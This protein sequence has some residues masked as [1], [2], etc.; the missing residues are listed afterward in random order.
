MLILALLELVADL[1]PII[2]VV[3]GGGIT[4]L[5]VLHE[6]Q[7]NRDTNNDVVPNFSILQQA[8]LSAL[9]QKEPQF[10][11]AQ[12]TAWA[13]SLFRQVATASNIKALE[14]IRPCITD[15]LYQNCKERF[16]RLEKQGLREIYEWFVDKSV[17]I[18]AYQDQGQREQLTVV[19]QISTSCY[20]MDV[21]TYRAVSGKPNT[22]IYLEYELT[23]VRY[24]DEKAKDG[25]QTK[26]CPHC[27]APVEG[28]Q[29]RQCDYCKSKLPVFNSNTKKNHDWTL[30]RCI[31]IKE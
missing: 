8:N 21:K 9:K 1:F 28:K 12:F 4:L 6:E 13:W 24:N 2:I 25:V 23:F 26:C 3:V 19:M 18:T 22:K 10:S 17:V 15:G 30:S 31:K 16:E 5:F 14:P 29:Q 11:P 27:G 20:M 7:K